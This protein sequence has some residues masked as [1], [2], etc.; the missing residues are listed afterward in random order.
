MIRRY[1][2]RPIIGQRYKL[3]PGA[4]AIL[5]REGQFLMAYQGAPYND[6]LLPG[7]GIDP[8]ESAIQALHREVFEETGWHI[9]RP[10]KIGAFRRFVWMPEY[11]KFAEKLCHIYTAFPVRRHGD[12]IEPD[13]TPIWVTPEIALAELSN[14]GDKD[15]LERALSSGRFRSE[16]SKR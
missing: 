10:R 2:D 14:K 9:A 16:T 5:P 6:L 11:D 8:G 13:H 7:G 1:G 4:Y 12:P 15:F 3:R